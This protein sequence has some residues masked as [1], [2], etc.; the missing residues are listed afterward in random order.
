MFMKFLAPVCRGLGRE[1][2]EY[3]VGK[4]GEVGYPPDIPPEI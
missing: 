4:Y 2:F 1:G 3:R